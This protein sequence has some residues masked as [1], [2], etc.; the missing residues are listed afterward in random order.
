MILTKLMPFY[1]SL[2][3]KDGRIAAAKAVEDIHQAGQTIE[4]YFREEMNKGGEQA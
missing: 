3:F 2:D 4:Q 1:K